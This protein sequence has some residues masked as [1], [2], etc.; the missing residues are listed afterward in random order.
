MFTVTCDG[1]VKDIQT[2]GD[3]KMSN[4]TNMAEIIKNTSGMWVPALK[5]GK[6]GDCIFFGKKTILG[7]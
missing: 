1:M 7:N 3:P 4:W 5:D 6:P 2:L